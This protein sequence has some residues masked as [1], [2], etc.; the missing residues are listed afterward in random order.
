MAK[1]VTGRNATSVSERVAEASNILVLARSFPDGAA[2]VCIDLLGGD[3][4]D[5]A[6]VLAVTYTQSP[7]Q[8]AADWERA[9]GTTPADGTV[10]SV[11]DWGEDDAT[12]SRWTIETVDHA[13]DL[14]T[15]GITLSEFLEAEPSEGAG[16]KRLCFDSLTALLQFIDLK[17][18][19][20]FLHVI[21]GRVSSAGAVA[22]YH[23]DPEAHDEQ[24]VATI[25]GLFDAV[26]EVDD[27]G[28]WAVTT[29]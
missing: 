9:T 1:Q 14:T 15:L 17:Q 10:I 13:G 26:V 4:R 2:G 16:H 22:H 25:R 12:P 24:T 7:G 11:G 6:S 3:S 8:W 19:F 21:T 23:L 29:R 18:A 28:D 20:Q 27:R 5:P